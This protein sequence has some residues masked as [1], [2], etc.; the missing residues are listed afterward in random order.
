MVFQSYAIWPHLTVFQNVAYPLAGQGRVAG[1]VMAILER[2]SLGHLADRLAPN[3]SGGQQQRVALARALVGQPE[4]LLLDEPLSNLDAK[5]REQMRIELRA[6]Q[7]R[8]G[9]TAVYVT[10]DQTEALAISDFI[11]VMNAG[12]LV[13]YGAPTEI[14]NRPKSRFAAEFM[15][16]ANVVSVRDAQ[17]VNGRICGQ[18]PWG[19]IYFMHNGQ[20]TPRSVVIRPEDIQIASCA[21]GDNVWPA[22]IEQVV[23]L[24]AIYDCRLALGGGT[25]RA[26]FPRTAMVE[27]DQQIHVHVDDRRCVPLEE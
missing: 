10:H 24:G 4:V 5:L 2:L 1:R 26:Q 13:E 6:L 15:G 9:L 18:V 19:A 20:A 7:Q 23:F 3:L 22:K 14:Y 21:T 11:G 8:V 12:Q 17:P 25:L 16:A 27:A